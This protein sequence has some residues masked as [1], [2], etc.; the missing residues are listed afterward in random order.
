MVVHL[1]GLAGSSLASVF[2]SFVPVVFCGVVC[3][4]L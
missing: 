3:G 1:F 2:R 4:L